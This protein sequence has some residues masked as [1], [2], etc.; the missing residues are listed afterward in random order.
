MRRFLWRGIYIIYPPLLRLLEHC[1]IHVKRQ[2]FRLGVLN[3]KASWKDIKKYLIKQ[4]FEDAIL[5]WKDPDEILSMRKIDKEIFQYHLRIFS[6]M[7]VR[8]HYEYSSEGNPWRHVT[9]KKFEPASNYFNTLLK[10]YLKE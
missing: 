9:E 1:N 7:E 3:H 8:G 10:S 5:A 2:D 4:G 6:D